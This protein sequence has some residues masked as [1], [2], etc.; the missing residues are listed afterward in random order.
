VNPKSLETLTDCRLEPGLA[1]AKP[2]D[3]FQFERSGYF[4]VDPDSARG[5]LVFNRTVTLKD[6]WAK[7]EQKADLRGL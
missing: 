2:G 7:I 1:E 4:C 6:T 5:K 3:K